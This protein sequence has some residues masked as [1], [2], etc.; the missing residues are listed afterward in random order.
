MQDAIKEQNA[1]S[2][3]LPR[4]QECVWPAGSVAHHLQ[5]DAVC[6]TNELSSALLC[7]AVDMLSLHFSGKVQ[8]ECL[9][10]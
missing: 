7:F 9:Q 4:A 8:T 10:E 5:S 1:E 2:S 6:P 3:V